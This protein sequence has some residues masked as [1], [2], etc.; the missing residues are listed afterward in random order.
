MKDTINNA[1]AGGATHAGFRLVVTGPTH[2]QIYTMN[3]PEDRISKLILQ[4]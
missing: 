3:A 2:A 1:L 4:Q